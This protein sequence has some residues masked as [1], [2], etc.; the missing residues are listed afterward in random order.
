MSAKCVIK[1]CILIGVQ[2]SLDRQVTWHRC[3]LLWPS[4]GRLQVYIL[5]RKEWCRCV[6]VWPGIM[7]VCDCVRGSCGWYMS[8][9]A[10]GTMHVLGWRWSVGPIT[11]SMSGSLPQSPSSNQRLCI[12]QETLAIHRCYGGLNKT[13]STNSFIAHCTN[14][15]C[16]YMSL[17]AWWWIRRVHFLTYMTAV[18][19]S[20]E[21]YFVRQT[22][23]IYGPPKLI[24][25]NVF[26][27]P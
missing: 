12:S 2:A 24:R 13:S 1:N 22:E 26:S 10:T 14:I 6:I 19:F 7:W 27:S 20:T 16:L 23:A 9:G 8:L 25:R 15:T 21:A 5:M 17:H 4:S 18:I 3:F 11:S